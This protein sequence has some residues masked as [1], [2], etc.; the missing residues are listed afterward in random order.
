[1]NREATLPF[2]IRTNT[3]YQV[4]MISSSSKDIRK[5]IVLK[6]LLTL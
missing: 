5:G 6:N 4:F 1:M 2:C 3:D